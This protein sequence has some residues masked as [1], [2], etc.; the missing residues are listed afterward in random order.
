MIEPAE[1]PGDLKAEEF[2]T[3]IG[4]YRLLEKIGEGGFGSVYVA[5]QKEPVRRRVALKVLKLGMD[6]RRVIARFE[7]ERQALALMDHPHIARVLDA[8]ATGSGRPYFVMELVRGA[9]ITDFCR[10][11]KLSIRDRLELFIQVCSA[12][13]HAHQKG[14]I[15]RDLK[16]S[17]LLVTTID[18]VPVPKVIDFGIAK[19][20][21]D[22]QL[23]DKTI[24]T[25]F[26]QF[27]GTPAY[28]SPE[29]A[30]LSGVDVDTR[31]DIYSLGVLLYELL[32][33]TTPFDTQELLKSGLDEVRRTIREQEPPR[34]STRITR[35]LSAGSPEMLQE[36]RELLRVVRGDLDWIVMQCLEKDR[37]RRYESANELAVD[38][39]R[40][41]R[42][43]PVLACPPSAGYRFQKLFRRN[44]I[45]VIATVAVALSLVLGFVVSTSLFWREKLARERAVKAEREQ[46][47]S[48]RQAEQARTEA[49]QANV[50]LASNLQQLEWER[51][52]ELIA[53]GR[54]ADAL[55]LF[56]RFLRETPDNSLVATRILSALSQR[57]FALPIARPLRHG[58]KVGSL[59]F[60]PAGDQ[61]LTSG[62]D[63]LVK[64]WRADTGALQ[65]ILTNGTADFVSFSADG[66]RVI[67][68]SNDRQTRV[69]D[70]VNGRL[71]ARL[72]AGGAN[73]CAAD[74]R[75]AVLAPDRLL[76]IWNG[77]TNEPL[78]EELKPLTDV[79]RADWSRDGKW[80]AV[81][82]ADGA[83]RL[84]DTAT[85]QPVRGP[86][87]FA[88]EVSMLRFSPDGER[89]MAGTKNGIVAFLNPRTGEVVRETKSGEYEITAAE[90]SSDGRYLITTI[91]NDRIRLW[92]GRTG[93]AL[94]PSFGDLALSS[95]RWAPDNRRLVIA[96]GGTAR[97]WDALEQ[98]PLSEPFE[99]EGPIDQ[100]D[101]GP[102]GH[103]VAT[104]S[105]DGT[106]RLWDV[107]MR[108]PA[109]VSWPLPGKP[110]GVRFSADGSRVAVAAGDSARIH[111]TRT[112]EPLTPPMS[113]RNVVYAG[114]FSPDGRVLA[115]TSDD[116]TVKLWHTASGQALGE[117]LVHNETT[118]TADFSPDGRWLATSSRD[119][120][121][122]VFEVQTR[123]LINS[124]QHPG[125]IIG[126]EFSPDG[127][128]V[129][130]SCVDGGMRLISTDTMKLVVPV[131]QHGGIIWSAVFSPDGARIAS[132]SAD[133][134]AQVWDARTGQP[135][136]QPL[137]HTKVVWTA[138]FN[139][140]GRQIVTASDD[141]TARVWDAAT[142]EP[143]SQ[144]MRRPVNR[145]VWYASFSP[146]GRWVLTLDEAGSYLWDARTGYSV[147]EAMLH[148]K[149]MDR[150]RFTPDGK[151]VLTTSLDLTAR[152][153]DINVAPSP[154]APWLA[155]LAEA[156]A[157]RRLNA[158][159]DSQPVSQQEL[160]ALKERLSA[161]A[162]TDFYSR[163]ARWF[164]VERLQEPT[165]LK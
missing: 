30:E 120:F 15:H 77:E 103:T 79:R 53:A 165:P 61:V 19:A 5:E 31:S 133:R 20:T 122:R 62:A 66:R 52:E 42:H 24:Y 161:G 51:A 156:L 116:K 72:P 74:Y 33:G 152:F 106:A 114:S 68:S 82:G 98:Q 160:Q 18:G 96:A 97:I 81:G 83:I 89:L 34:P 48:R 95:A 94:S 14:I 88:G 93:A 91:Y 134:T 8:G 38:I 6:T 46:D 60:N 158:R 141:G 105:Q 113:H 71:I 40:H 12:V 54:R 47:Q 119:G 140:D 22:L 142:G 64:I 144:P 2:G 163:W 101:F 3:V 136:G 17:N 43:E 16:P 11:H 41:L 45:A 121:L 36:R 32:V 75:L 155:D 7:A 123:R 147:S 4:R 143:I 150:A 13:Q 86:N 27:I 148:S 76:R 49:D 37:A 118:W 124:L 128:A 50:R 35:D 55:A 115:T 129:L 57:N 117:P 99:H 39:Q 84:W 146:D 153:W 70:A 67:A 21:G 157:G 10:E 102:D 109:A 59:Q 125:E 127:K 138:L 23:T 126:A 149:P 164:F 131:M 145:A 26:Q 135:L 29:Q 104:G 107:R 108:L 65:L 63:G 130:T 85:W 90:F 154:V 111:D 159:R 80:L 73:V 139:P 132:A 137:R 151:Q 162:E 56:A 69:W 112:G 58:G 92:D 28:M 110:R 25:Q 44:K 78:G 100:V 87:R 1:S 9:R